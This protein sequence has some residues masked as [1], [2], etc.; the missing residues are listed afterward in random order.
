MGASN[1]ARDSN[2]RFSQGNGPPDGTHDQ[3]NTIPKS[4]F[5]VGGAVKSRYTGSWRDPASGVLCVEKSNRVT[6]LEQAKSLGRQRN[7][8]SIYDI[9]RGRTIPT[10]GNGKT[11]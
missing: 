6:N 3:Y 1:Q 5:M 7:Q 8:I 4:G 2:G 9:E 11:L 10:G